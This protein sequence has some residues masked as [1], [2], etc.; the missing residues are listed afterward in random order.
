MYTIGMHVSYQL[1]HRRAPWHPF[2]YII[3][4]EDGLLYQVRQTGFRKY[5]QFED[6]INHRILY[7]IGMMTIKSTEDEEILA[8]VAKELTRPLANSL[9]RI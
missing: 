3:K 1:D 9:S 8:K 4:S 7:Y 2:R 5:R 6:G